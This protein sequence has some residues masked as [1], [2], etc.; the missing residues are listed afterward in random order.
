MNI[1]KFFS[2]TDQPIHLYPS[3]KNTVQNVTQIEAIKLDSLK[4]F[5]EIKL[6]K[7]DCEGTEIETLKGATK[8][9]KKTKYVSVD[10]SDDIG[11]KIKV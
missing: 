6:I 5:G 1:E 2:V 11:Q 8:I 3:G 9:L 7:I 10:V 4:I